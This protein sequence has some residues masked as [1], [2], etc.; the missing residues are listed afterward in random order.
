ML[1]LCKRVCS[2]PVLAANVAWG[3]LLFAAERG[4]TEPTY[5]YRTIDPPGST[6]FRASGINNAGQIVESDRFG[7]FLFDGTSYTRIMDVNGASQTTAWG[8]NASGDITGS[9]VVGVVRGP[10]HGFLLSGGS[11]TTLDPPG[12]KQTNA[13]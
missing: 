9:Y 2:V 7:S 5:V 3:L 13:F 6:F 4:N 8:I 10:I 12:S 1:S 11:Y